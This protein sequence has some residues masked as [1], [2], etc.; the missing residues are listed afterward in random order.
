[1]EIF[2]LFQI[3]DLS[4]SSFS[5]KKIGLIRLLFFLLVYL[6]A[7][8]ETEISFDPGEIITDVDTDIDPGWWQGRNEAGAFGLFPANYVELIK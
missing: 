2:F 4:L 6:C 3:N 7:A 5:K 1:M 8:D